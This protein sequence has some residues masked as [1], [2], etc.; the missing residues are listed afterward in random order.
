ME[1]TKMLRTVRDAA[2]D[3]RAV[4]LLAM[5]TQYQNETFSDDDDHLAEV[6]KGTIRRIRRLTNIK[7]MRKSFRTIH[8]SVSSF[9]SGGIGKLFVPSHATNKQIA[10][11]FCDPDT[12]ILSSITLCR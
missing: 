3:D 6:N 2:Y 8:A 1:A 11:K 12:R 5:L 7:N 4:H 9:H 10:A